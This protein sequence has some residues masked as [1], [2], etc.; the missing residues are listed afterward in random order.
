MRKKGK[1][2]TGETGNLTEVVVNA[3]PEMTTDS[4]A[5]VLEKM[6]SD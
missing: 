5:A 1:P 6:I 4:C 2:I 3:S